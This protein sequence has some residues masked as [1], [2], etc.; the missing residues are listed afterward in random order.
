MLSD[1]VSAKDSDNRIESG[2]PPLRKININL[3]V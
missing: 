2:L 1:D 3:G